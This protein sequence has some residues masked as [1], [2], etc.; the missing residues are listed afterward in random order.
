MV[1]PACPFC[2]REYRDEYRVDGRHHHA[3]AGQTRKEIG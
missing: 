2:G 1:R 3:A